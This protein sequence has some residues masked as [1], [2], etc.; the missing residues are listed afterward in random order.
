MHEMQSYM[1]PWLVYF[2][3]VIGAEYTELP[4]EEPRLFRRSVPVLF[5][6]PSSNLGSQYIR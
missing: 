1:K 2:K 4:E 5:T 6:T 3:E